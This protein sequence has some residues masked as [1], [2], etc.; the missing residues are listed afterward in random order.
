[1]SSSVVLRRCATLSE[2]HI[3]A[4]LLNSRDIWAVVDNAEHA[5][6]DWGSVCAFGGVYVR[7]F[8]SDYE[9]AKQEIIDSVLAAPAVLKDL[10]GSIEPLPNA[11][12]WRAISMLLIYLGV[13]NFFGGLL[14]IFVIPLIPPEW[15]PQTQANDYWFDI[16]SGVSTAPPGPGA[17]GLILVLMIA[18]FLLWELR[19][20]QPTNPKK[21]PQV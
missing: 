21:E 6:V 12:R 16:S 17:N 2:A 19:T 10:S 7:V 3:C 14:L 15:V 8:A 1:M 5:A 9:R 18:S 4:G 11:R 20:T 13:V